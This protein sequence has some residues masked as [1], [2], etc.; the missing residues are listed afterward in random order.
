MFEPLPIARHL[1]A[2]DS[3]RV[4]VVARA[5]DPP[6]APISQHGHLERTGARTVVRASGLGEGL[7]Q[8]WHATSF[9]RAVGRETC[10]FL[11]VRNIRAVA[12]VWHPLV[13]TSWS[14]SLISDTR[15]RDGG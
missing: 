8:I 9:A 11:A 4:A 5:R 10:H 1:G 14:F 7:H 3:Q 15:V 2:Y 6:D 12:P 13:W